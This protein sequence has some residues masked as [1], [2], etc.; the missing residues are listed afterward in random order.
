MRDSESYFNTTAE[1][2]PELEIYESK[3][4]HQDQAA[5]DFLQHNF[6][7]YF[8]AEQIHNMIMENAPLTSTRRALS[9]LFNAGLIEKGAKVQGMYSRPIYTWRWKTQQIDLFTGKPE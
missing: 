7:E 4:S 6:A 3:A 2:N 9:N 5:R 1:I 8:T